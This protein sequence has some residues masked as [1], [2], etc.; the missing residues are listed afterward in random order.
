[1][2]LD[3][4]LK[5]DLYVGG[6]YEHNEVTGVISV[7]RRGKTY[8]IEPTDVVKITL[9]VGYWR[10]AN[11]IHKWFVD[12]VQ[13]GVDECQRAWVSKDKLKELKELVEQELEARGSKRAGQALPPCEGFFFGSQE[14]DDWYYDDM[15]QTLKIIDKALALPDEYDINYQSSW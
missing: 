6:M 13:D 8:V 14:I 2:G 7:T 15:E 1:M 11:A 10:K 9:N 5:A 4:Y 3:M 12:K